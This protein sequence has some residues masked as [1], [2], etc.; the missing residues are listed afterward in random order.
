[1][2]EEAHAV[3]STASGCLAVQP[4]GTGRHAAS[5]GY[6]EPRPPD[7]GSVADETL[8]SLLKA[9]IEHRR[10]DNAMAGMDREQN[11]FYFEK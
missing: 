4:D 5:T 9:A 1:M 10:I 11:Y 2:D 6:F 7:T 3:Q 8:T